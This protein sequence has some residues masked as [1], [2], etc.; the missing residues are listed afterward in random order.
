MWD[1]R[2]SSRNGGLRVEEVMK[3]KRQR[4]RREGRRGKKSKIESR[5]G[6]HKMAVRSKIIH[7]GARGAWSQG[8]RVERFCK[9]TY[10]TKGNTLHQF[11]RSVTLS[12]TPRVVLVVILR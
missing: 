12:F 9:G 11:L 8:R 6:H 7:S 1:K 4:R 3:E 10:G 2:V 5:L